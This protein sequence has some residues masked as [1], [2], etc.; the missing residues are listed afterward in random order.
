MA[1][2]IKHLHNLSPHHYVSTL[3]DITQQLK[4]YVVFF[5]MVWV[6]LKR[7]GFGG[8]EERWGGKLCASIQTWLQCFINHL[9]TY[10]LTYVRI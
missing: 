5:S 2:A 7:T 9:L 8:S 3:P 6:A 10:W 4:S 1:L